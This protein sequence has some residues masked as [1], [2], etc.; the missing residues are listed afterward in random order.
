MFGRLS[1]ISAFILL[2]ANIS[3]AQVADSAQQISDVVIIGNKEQS[4]VGRI[5]AAVSSLSATGVYSNRVESPNE[6]TAIVPNFYM[7]DYGSKL[8]SAIYIRGIGSRMNESAVGLYV[9]NAPYLDKSAYD[10]D[11]FDIAKIDVLRGP[12]GTLYGRNTIG[13]II[14][15]YTP[16]PLAYQGTKARATYGNANTLDLQA[17]HYHKFG[18]NLGVSAGISY[19]QADGFFT[20]SYNGKP[21]DEMQSIG[22]RV[23]LD[24]NI[25]SKLQL[26]YSLSGEHSAQNGYP[27]GLVGSTGEVKDISQNDPSNYRR[28]LVNNSLRLQY[29]GYGYTL[30]STTNYQ[31]MNDHMKMDQDFSSEPVF[32]LEQMQKQNA[33]SEEILIKSKSEKNYQWLF[34][35]FAFYK[36]MNTEAPVDLKSGFI[37]QLSQMFPPPTSPVQISIVTDSGSTAQADNIYIPSGFES[38]TYGFAAYHQSTYN[39]LIIKGLSATVGLRLDYEKVSLKYGSTSGITARVVA[40]PTMGGINWYS[41]APQPLYDGSCKNYFFELLPKVALQYEFDSKRHRLYATVAKGYTS[42]GYNTNLFADLVRDKLEPMR[43]GATITFKRPEDNAAVAKAIYYKPEYSWN[44]E[45]G[46]SANLFTNRLQA[47]ASLFYIHTQD[48]QIAQFVPSGYGRVMKNAGK[49]ESYGAEVSLQGRVGN[50]SLSADYGYTHAAFTKYQDTSIV[51]TDGVKDTVPLNYSG[52][53]VPFAPQNTLAL[54]ADYTLN[55]YKKPIDRITFGVQY[56]GV[57]K[58]YFTADNNRSQNFYGL[59]NGNIRLEKSIFSINIWSKNILDK[60]YKVFLFESGKNTYA[61]P[62]RPL[63]FG[64]DLIVKF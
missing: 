55:L 64:I 6:L 42:G 51:T 50:L 18:S 48:L 8:S 37:T 10:F 34:G 44:Y 9:D 62:G 20:N 36:K 63:Q 26:S 2:F 59:L 28:D 24:W 41:S 13:G 46:G 58:I 15:I 57:G 12:Q 43:S 19:R 31:H 7:P 45:A 22:E 14:N 17:L 49:S 35:A 53:Y 40:P 61:Q 5:P 16:S 39:N 60:K 29:N 23:R 27:Y 1:T 11:F 38:P 47:S 52:S 33:I 54:T 56:V 21:A 30:S 4:S 25:T 3:Q 32:T